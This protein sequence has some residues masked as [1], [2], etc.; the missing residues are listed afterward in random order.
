MQGVVTRE[1]S[2]RLHAAR[3]C[4]AVTRPHYDTTQDGHSP[5][6]TNPDLEQR[7]ASLGVLVNAHATSLDAHD[8]SIA[9]LES[10]SPAAQLDVFS[11]PNGETSSMIPGQVVSTF[12]NSVSFARAS[13]ELAASVQGLVVGGAGPT[14]PVRV[15]CAGAVELTEAEWDAASG[16]SGGLVPGARYYLDVAAGRMTA[17]A[18]TA[19]GTFV[20][21]LG[22]AIT[23]T[24]FVLRVCAYIQN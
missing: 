6:R 14:L 21:A 5:A 3:T 16:S 12:N 23:S 10:S 8:D 13:S 18:P 15:Q 11:A 20:T 19:P 24:L 22:R 2:N 17:V 7:I 4:K 1:D 9:S